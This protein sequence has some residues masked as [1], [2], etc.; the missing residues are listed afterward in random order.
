MI[1]REYPKICCIFTYVCIIEVQHI[2]IIAQ[3][4]TKLL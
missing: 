3:I 4:V 2:K 1:D